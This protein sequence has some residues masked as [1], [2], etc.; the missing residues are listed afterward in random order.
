MTLLRD[1]APAS[2]VRARPLLQV[3]TNIASCMGAPAIS[4]LWRKQTSYQQIETAK[5]AENETD[6]R[7]QR[8]GVPH[9]GGGVLRLSHRGIN[10]FEV[11]LIRHMDISV[12]GFVILHKIVTAFLYV[13]SA[14]LVRPA[15]IDDAAGEHCCLRHCDLGGCPI[16]F[17][18]DGRQPHMTT[19]ILSTPAG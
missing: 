5:A 14:A 3:S 11:I 6:G 13:A 16:Q 12:S 2:A 15:L 8:V 18:E 19:R 10:G 1:R 9:P 7:R 4:N 17:S